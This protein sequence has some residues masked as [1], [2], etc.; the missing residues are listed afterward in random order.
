MGLGIFGI[1]ALAYGWVANYLIMRD[2]RRF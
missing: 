2:G 1:G